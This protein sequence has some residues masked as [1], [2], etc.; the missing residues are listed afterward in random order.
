MNRCTA[1][2]LALFALTATAAGEERRADPPLVV[3]GDVSLT[4]ADYKAYLEKVPQQLRDDFSSGTERVRKTVDGLWVQRMVARKARAERLAEDPIVAARLVQAQEAVLVEVYLRNIEKTLKY[5]DLLPRAREVYRAQPE[6]FTQPG[7]VHVQHILVDMKCRKRDEALKRAEE[8]R[9]EALGAKEE[10]T[11]LARRHSDDPSKEKNGGDLGLVAAS[12]YDEQFRAGIA[13]LQ[14]PG[15]ISQPIETRFG[16]HVVRLVNREPERKRPFEE[17]KDQI[18]AAEKEKL[19]D[20]ARAQV[21]ASIRNDP[22]THLHLENVEALVEKP[23]AAAAGA[24]PK[25]R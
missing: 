18:I 5:P 16:F 8:L 24:E 25:A 19:L 13:K 23:K 10:F 2:V 7:K 4:T 11:A 1:L 21:L 9:A 20:E 17:V 14:K 6:K 22:K 15:E 12:A 3:N